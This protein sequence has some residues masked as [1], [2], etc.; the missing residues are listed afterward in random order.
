MKV[1]FQKNAEDV[2]LLAIY[3]AELT[4]QNVEYRVENRTSEFEVIIT[5]Y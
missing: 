4:R 3:L 1:K 2:K 5:G